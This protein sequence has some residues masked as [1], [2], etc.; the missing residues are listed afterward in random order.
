L[1]PV[2]KMGGKKGNN[3]IFVDIFEK[4]SILFNSSGFVIN[5]SIEGFIQMKSYLVGNPELRI[6]LNEDLIVGRQEGV[7]GRL[8]LDDCNFNE[9]VDTKAF[10]ANKVLRIK[11]PEGEFI[12][13]GYRTNSEYQAPFRLFPY[14]DEISNYKISLD[15]RIKACF[16]KEI[17]ASYI[18]AKIPMP[19]NVSNVTPELGKGVTNQVVDYKTTENFVEWQIKTCQGGQELG[20][21]IKITLPTNATV[22]AAKKEIGPI[23]LHFEISN[24]N[25]SGLNLKYLKVD[26]FKNIKVQ[27]WVRYVTQAASYVCRTS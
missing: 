13:M 20:L 19:K 14:I 16:P 1:R 5:S 9:C 23:S 7:S 17:T 27:R 22:Q 18:T 2:T 3:E 21:R 15:L 4:L 6:A 26:E 10:G 11:P 12:V 25:V 8:I 24:Y